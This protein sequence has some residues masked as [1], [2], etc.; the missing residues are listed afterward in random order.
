MLQ[1]H[2]NVERLL[3]HGFKPAWEPTGQ[4]IDAMTQLV[5]EAH[6]IDDCIT[7]PGLPNFMPPLIPEDA[8]WLELV[9]EV[10]HVSFLGLIADVWT[11]LLI[12][13][14]DAKEKPLYL[15]WDD[16]IPKPTRLTSLAWLLTCESWP[17]PNHRDGANLPMFPPQPFLLPQSTPYGFAGTSPRNYACGENRVVPANRSLNSLFGE[18]LNRGDRENMN[19]VEGFAPVYRPPMKTA[20]VVGF[21]LRDDF[22]HRY[23]QSEKWPRVTNR[24]IDHGLASHE[25]FDSYIYLNELHALRASV[26]ERLLTQPGM[27]THRSTLHTPPGMSIRNWSINGIIAKPL[28]HGSKLQWTPDGDPLK[29]E[30]GATLKTVPTAAPRVWFGFTSLG[31]Q[32]EESADGLRETASERW[33]AAYLKHREF[34]IR[35]LFSPESIDREQLLHEASAERAKRLE[36]A[37]RLK[38]QTAAAVGFAAAF[39]NIVK[40]EN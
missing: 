36:R 10:A 16:D 39:A 34:A 28:A 11:Q 27:P 7:I 33:V 23:S 3:S 14:R 6:G 26:M 15:F 21:H 13:K 1:L 25:I 38:K 17:M 8:N 4:M 12:A 18:V 22:E 24:L 20:T 2:K 5:R 37:G 40:K 32:Y 30:H 19:Q 31:P 35:M 29:L 9:H